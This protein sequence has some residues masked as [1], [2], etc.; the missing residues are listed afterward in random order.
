MIESIVLM[1]DERTRKSFEAMSAEDAGNILKGL[2]R[3]AAGEEIDTSAWSDIALAVYP[4]I[5]GQVDRMT[6]LREKRSAAGRASA[7]S[8]AEANSNKPSANCNKL[9]TNLQQVATTD[10]QVATPVPV[11]IPKPIKETT[12]T[13]SKEKFAAA[14]EAY[15]KKQGRKEA[16]AAYLRAIRDGTT[17]EQIMAGIEAY[18]AYIKRCRVP[19]QYVKQ[20]STFFRQAAWTDDWTGMMRPIGFNFTPRGTDYDALLTEVGV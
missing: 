3:H 9:A 14:W 16:E 7:E 6:D 19:D 17:H 18:K 12:L 5:E 11:P 1:T 4:L 10:Q 13:G 20:G 2:L 15:P 8:K